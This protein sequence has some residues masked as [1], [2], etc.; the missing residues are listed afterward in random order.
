MLVI[1]HWSLVALLEEFKLLGAHLGD[2]EQDAPFFIFVDSKHQHMA[3]DGIAR[4]D[5]FAISTSVTAVEYMVQDSS[6]AWIWVKS[7][8][9]L[10]H[11]AISV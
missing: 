11:S 5:G 2:R 10:S 6:A 4:L 3:I 8:F 9:S 1:I 7:Y